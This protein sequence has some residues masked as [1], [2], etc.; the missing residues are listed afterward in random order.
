MKFLSNAITVAVLLLMMITNNRLFAQET[1]TEANEDRPDLSWEQDARRTMDPALGYVPGERLILA[2][3]IA[4][5]RQQQNYKSGPV[6]NVNWTERGPSNVGGRTRALMFD[7]NDANHKKVWA[8]G[9]TG[10]LWYNNDITNATSTWTKVND[11]WSNITVSCIAHDPIDPKIFYVGTGES[12]VS[13]GLGSG[14]W[15]STDAGT[16]WTQLPSTTDF[17]FV[18]KI[19]VRNE[20]GTSV[21]YAGIAVSFYVSNYHGHSEGLQRSTDGGTT[22]TQVLPNI[23]ATSSAYRAR[24]IEIGADNRIYVGTA[25]SL[26]G[27]AIAGGGTI[28]YSDLGTSGSWTVNTTYSSISGVGRVELACAPS[29]PN[30]VYAMIEASNHIQNIAK[31]GDKG[32]TWT[33]LNLPVDADN[34][35]IPAGDFTRGQAWYDLTLAVDPN[36]AS[37]LI[38]GGIDLFQSTDGGNSWG[39]ISQWMSLGLPNS[40]VH[41]DQHA[42]IFAPGSSSTLIFGNDGGVFYTSN[43]AG[44]RNNTTISS[45]NNGYNVTQFY[46]CASN[47]TKGSN[48]FLAGAQDNGTQQFTSSGLGSTVSATGG[49]GAFCFIDNLDPTIQITAYT[50]NCYYLSLDGGS[51]FQI[52][53]YDQNSG[54]FINPTEYDSKESILYSAYNKDSIQLI[55]DISSGSPF[56][57]TVFIGMDSIATHLKVSPYTLPGNSTVFIGTAKGSV[58]KVINPQG[59]PTIIDISGNLPHGSVSCIEIGASEN[60]LLVTFFNYGL[61]SVWQTSNGGANWVNKEGDLPDMPVRWALYNPHNRQQVLLATEV[62]VWS[63][64]SI[65]VATPDWQPSNSGLANVRV[66]ML[67]YRSSDRLVTAATYGRG[68]FTSDVF[69]D[70]IPPTATTLNPANNATAVATNAALTITFDK[71]IQK[72]TG[73]ILIK[74]SGLTT[75]NI[76]VSSPS[77]SVSGNTATI[78]PPAHFTSN[79]S[80][81]INIAAT[82]FKDLANN[83]YAGIFNLS[84]WHFTVGP[85]SVLDFNSQEETFTIYPNP[86]HGQFA[87]NFNGAANHPFSVEIMSMNGQ[88]VYK[89]NIRDLPIT[90]LF[91]ID[92]GDVSPGIYLLKL[93]TEQGMKK[94]KLSVMR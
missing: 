83:N 64:D 74:E 45:R 66:D 24:D 18:N 10:G 55:T 22:F 65:N 86:N 1:K 47:P 37:S 88:C 75:Q 19:V 39:Q 29:D 50:N 3:K 59:N 67:K 77:V 53:N 33:N 58:F 91:Q 31:S 94:V 85:T 46:S 2:N 11:F 68:L 35:S 16:T 21:V 93:Q 76:D 61:V 49:D 8:G 9:V 4:Q 81:S 63:T 20:S 40:V 14:I 73:A 51:T 32:V 57:F 6:P 28:L 44:A 13:S 27:S 34:Q 26:A 30:V 12:R 38:I 79:A 92:M 70:T 25:Q 87:V 90:N 62:G 43:L 60:D 52:I 89:Q 78:T 5:N 23:P 7:P 84:T 72:G 15:K 36:S 82:T 69:S 42:I 54:S 56:A 48:Y 41:A 17:N 80:V 71:S